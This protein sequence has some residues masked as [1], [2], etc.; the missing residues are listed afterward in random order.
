MSRQ[1]SELRRLIK[2]CCEQSEAADKAAL[3]AART[4]DRALASV[5]NL[6]GRLSTLEHLVRQALRG[7][8]GVRRPRNPV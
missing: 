5:E 8:S 3:R 7:A 1:Y 6:R 2:V 4:G